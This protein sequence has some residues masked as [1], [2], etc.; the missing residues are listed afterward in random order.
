MKSKRSRDGSPRVGAGERVK[1]H[2]RLAISFALLVALA[3]LPRAASAW[4]AQQVP[5]RSYCAAWTWRISRAGSVARQSQGPG[6]TARAVAGGASI[7][8]YELSAPVPAA[9]SVELT[10]QT[11]KGWYRVTAPFV[12]LAR[13]DGTYR[14]SEATFRRYAVHSPAQFFELPFAA[15]R[16]RYLWV[17]KVG[18]A[19]ASPTTRC[20]AM[21]IGYHQHKKRKKVPRVGSRK[22][23][24]LHRVKRLNPSVYNR[25]A[26]PPVGSIAEARAIREP[27][28]A[29]TCRRPF[30]AA[31]VKSVVPPTYPALYTENGEGASAIVDVEVE[32]APDGRVVGRELVG[33]SGMRLFDGNALYAA[34]QTTYSPKI[35]LCRPVPGFYIFDAQYMPG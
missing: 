33:P 8:R 30:I 27:A 21:W 5:F 13:D 18:N 11:T 3:A 23:F 29:T 4:Q 7:W 15:G 26:R 24:A 1:H 32:I 20:P 25:R 10:M 2:R 16:P 17:S 28:S 14:S 19:G 6:A 35:G 22:W 9:L 12:P 34:S 31:K